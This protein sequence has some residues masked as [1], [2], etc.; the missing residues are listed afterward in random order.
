MDDIDRKML[1]QLDS[2]FPNERSNTVELWREKLK[3]AGRTFRDLV[4]EIETAVPLNQHQAVEAQLHQYAQ[5]N[6]GLVRKLH[7][8]QI[9]LATYQGVL[10]IRRYWRRA[11]A[12]VMLPVVAFVGWE[13]YQSTATAAE[14]EA[15]DSAFQKI[16]VATA[17]LKT[18]QDS[19]P[20]V[21]D[22][23]GASYWVIVR[24]DQDEAHRDRNGRPVTVQCVRLFAEKAER[25]AGAYLEPRPYA[26]WGQGWLTWPK[27]AV[28]CRTD[29]MRSGK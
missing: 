22:V 11:T 10:S 8:A 13:Y 29:T 21:L 26:F 3:T 23:A 7:A 14:R 25:D 1:A 15:R 12:Y 19:A 24:R 4:Q 6:A 27:R 17:W 28:D 18:D 5:A 16:A 20:V 9:K 2:D